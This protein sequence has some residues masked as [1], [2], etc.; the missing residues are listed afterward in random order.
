MTQSAPP[1]LAH[2][3]SVRSWVRHHKKLE[4]VARTTPQRGCCI[5][6]IQSTTCLVPSGL[7]WAQVLTT[8]R[9]VQGPGSGWAEADP[10]SQPHLARLW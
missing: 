8:H 4:K 3:V 10:F 1:C 5:P 2:L 7:C 6:S 9:G